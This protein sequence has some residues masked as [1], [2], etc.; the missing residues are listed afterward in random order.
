MFEEADSNNCPFRMILNRDYG[1]FGVQ[2]AVFAFDDDAIG[3]FQGT[4]DRKKDFA[5][6][7]EFDDGVLE[8]DA[9]VLVGAGA[10]SVGVVIDIDIA[11]SAAEFDG[12][13]HR[14]GFGKELGQA[15]YDVLFECVNR[16]LVGHGETSTPELEQTNLP[17]FP[18]WKA[19]EE[20]SYALSAWSGARVPPNA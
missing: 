13:P 17:L 9:M 16:C 4:I 14:S 7:T 1:G 10:I 3:K 5:R 8:K 2:G 12:D 6:R 20:I 19:C 18:V 15:A 11:R